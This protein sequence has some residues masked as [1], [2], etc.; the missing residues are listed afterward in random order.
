MNC[1]SCTKP[2]DS[3]RAVKIHHK[4]AHGESISTEESVCS[5]E[6]CQNTFVYYPSEKEGVICPSCISEGKNIQDAGYD[7]PP[8]T[9]EAETVIVE[10]VVCGLTNE[11][12]RYKIKAKNYLCSKE[13]REEFQSERMKGENNPRYLDGESRGKKYNS[14]WRKVRKKAIERDNNSCQICQSEENLHVHH[15]I[16]VR[17]FENENDAH[18]LENCITL[19]P[20]CHRNIEY[21]NLEIPDEITLEKNLTTYDQKTFI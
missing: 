6:G 17:E 3:E 12:K 1:P 11:V 14:N 18:F 7:V 15:I 16:P 4:L 8:P 13:C 9:K 21:K 2:F 20:S 19:C 10:C 5:I